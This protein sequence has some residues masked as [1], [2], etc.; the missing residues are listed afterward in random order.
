MFDVEVD[1]VP[2]QEL[3]VDGGVVAQVFMFPP[4]F[5]EAMKARGITIE[6]DRRLF[7]IRNDRLD[8]DWATVERKTI[9]IAGRAITSLIHSQGIGDLYRIF[10]VAD[11]E[12][13]DYNLAYI[14]RDFN[15]PHEVEFDTKFMQALFDY[16]YQAARQ[17]YE[18]KK[19][20]SDRE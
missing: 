2:H 1:G 8:P 9:S 7:I 16:G 15:E 3:H 18:W 4:R 11:S 20:P 13:T 17:G 19:H 12:G 6:R 5:V 14:G 10:L